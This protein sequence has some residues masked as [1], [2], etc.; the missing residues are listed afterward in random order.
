MSTDEPFDGFEEPWGQK[1]WCILSQHFWFQVV[2]GRSNYGL[3]LGL[4]GLENC[5]LSPDL[6][7]ETDLRDVEVSLATKLCETHLNS[8]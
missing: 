6:V 2:V 3:L 8:L 5:F 7:Q 1:Q 4:R